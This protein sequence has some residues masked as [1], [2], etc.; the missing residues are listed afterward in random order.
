MCEDNENTT[1]GATETCSD[2]FVCFFFNKGMTQFYNLVNDKS[3]DVVG[4][5]KMG[6]MY[7]CVSVCTYI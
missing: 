4:I 5:E 3:A 1:V 7:V 2:E 6:E